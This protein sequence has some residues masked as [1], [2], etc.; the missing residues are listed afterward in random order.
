MPTRRCATAMSTRAGRSTITCAGM[1]KW[2]RVAPA[3]NSQIR[4]RC[5]RRLRSCILGRRA[6]GRHEPHMQKR[7]E[8]MT[9]LRALIADGLVVGVFGWVVDQLTPPPPMDDQAK[10][11]AEE[12]KW[13]DAAK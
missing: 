12:R 13:K 6:H 9:T 7:K 3:R 2:R 10:A 11:A 1:R 5:R 4:M 8:A